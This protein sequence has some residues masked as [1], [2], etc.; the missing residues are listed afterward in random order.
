MIST[1]ADIAQV[2]IAIVSVALA[3]SAFIYQRKKDM[4]ADNI[5]VE[6]SRRTE[7]L[8]WYRELLIHPNVSTIYGLFSD[9]TEISQKFTTPNLTDI[10]KSEILQ[11][12][13]NKVAAFRVAFVDLLEVVDVEK[14]KQSLD[15][16]DTLVDYIGIT[17]LDQGINLSHQPK[18]EE[19]ILQ[20]VSHTRNIFL[21]IISRFK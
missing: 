7:Q 4:H 16:L 17:T 5:N 11:E 19:S 14:R 2:V 18:F 10:Q 9:I 1:L 6:I 21:Q 13:K 8:Q 12:I 3:Y 20:K 15:V